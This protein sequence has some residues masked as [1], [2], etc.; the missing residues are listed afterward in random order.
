[1][2][3]IS[4]V[5]SCFILAGCSGL[6]PSVNKPNIKINTI[7][8]DQMDG[9]S[10]IVFNEWWKEYN[11]KKIN[12]LVSSMLTNNPDILLAKSKYIYSLES[13]NIDKSYTLPSVSVKD[14]MILNGEKTK[15]NKFGISISS[16]EL[17]YLG[18]IYDKNKVTDS[19]INISKNNYELLKSMLSYDIVSNYFNIVYLDKQLANSNTKIGVYQELA[20]I[21]KEK[22]NIGLSNKMDL[23]TVN[24]NLQNEIIL[25]HNISMEIINNK[26]SIELLTGEEFKLPKLNSELT[27][28]D[29]DENAIVTD[30]INNR[31]DI[32]NAELDLIAENAKIGLAKAQF[33]PVISLS[34]FLGYKNSNIND[35]FGPTTNFWSVSPS[36][37]FNIFDYGNNSSLLEQQKNMK[38]QALIKYVKT[39]KAAYL[40]VQT[41]YLNYEQNKMQLNASKNI[42][43]LSLNKYNIVL[44]NNKIGL[45]SGQD[46][47]I[48]FND[49]LNNKS[50]Y[51]KKLFDTIVSQLNLQKSLEGKI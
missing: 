5:L 23:D 37:M 18:K 8:N 6:S 3:T 16:F 22:V 50:N 11:N 42:Y 17:D 12:H 14:D 21:L 10:T 32:K 2:K 31:F 19:E 4:F 24:I 49:L 35:V 36:I 43:D 26:K 47:L 41:M 46:L 29:F 28:I 27:L 45:S 34:S 51:E 40:D 44:T 20:G 25:N 7:F 38:E 1:M 9:K 13:L 48:A 39:V 30:N 33:F 15:S